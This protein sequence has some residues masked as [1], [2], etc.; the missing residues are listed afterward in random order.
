MAATWADLKSGAS[1][2]EELADSLRAGRANWR[3]SVLEL[4]DGPAHSFEENLRHHPFVFVIE[5]MAVK[6]G[7]ALDH[8]IGEIHDHVNR[9][10]VGDIHGVQPQ[11]VCNRL[12]VFGVGQEMDLWMCIGCSSD[13]ALTILQCWY[14]PTFARAR[15][16]ASGANFSPLI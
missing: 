12:V 15:G 7:H 3:V 1:A 5:K 2:K 9:A 4:R 16:A 13:E 8:R 11:W 10:A 14:V 6:D